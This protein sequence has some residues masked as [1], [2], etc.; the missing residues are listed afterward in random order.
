M[1]G[2][3]T[4]ENQPTRRNECG[5]GV[6]GGSGKRGGARTELREAAGTDDGGRDGKGPVELKA[7]VPLLVRVA[8]EIAPV[9]VRMAPESMMTAPQLA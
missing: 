6:V 7:R 2:H 5:A 8:A 9:V 1:V 4:I 3:G